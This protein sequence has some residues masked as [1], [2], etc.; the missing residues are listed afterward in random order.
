MVIEEADQHKYFLLRSGCFDC[1][2]R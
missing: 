2:I 1:S